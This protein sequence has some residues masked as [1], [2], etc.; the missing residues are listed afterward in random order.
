MPTEMGKSEE[1]DCPIEGYPP[2]IY[3]WLKNKRQI[4]AL[5]GITIKMDKKDKFGDYT[6]KGQNDAG[7]ETV[8][9]SV[10]KNREHLKQ[11]YSICQVKAIHLSSRALLLLCRFSCWSGLRIV[12]VDDLFHNTP[13]QLPVLCF[14]V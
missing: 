8:V 3:S 12:R 5:K 9:F 6:C 4:T 14:C 13:A 10:V 7:V 11:Y 2:V 1:L